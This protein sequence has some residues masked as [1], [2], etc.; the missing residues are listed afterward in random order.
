MK[1]KLL[2]LIVV[3]VIAFG[4]KAQAPS[5]ISFSPKNGSVGTLVTINGTGFNNTD[6]V[7]IGG[8]PAIIISK[9]SNK[10]LA[11]VMPN[12]ITGSV[13]LY[14]PGIV[15]IFSDSF[16]INPTKF[17]KVQQGNKLVGTDHITQVNGSIWS[18]NQQGYTVAISA[19]GNTA[20]V[21]GWEYNHYQG[22]VWT[23][24]KIGNRWVQQGDKLTANNGIGYTQ[25]GGSVALSGDG[26][27]AI[28]GGNGDNGYLGAA[29]IFERNGGVWIQQGN[30]LV[31][32]GSVGNPV[33]QGGSVAI[34]VDGNTAIIGGK[35]DSGYV[36]ASWV[37]SKINNIWTQQG[38]K[39]IGTGISDSARQGNA[40]AI[41]ADGNTVIV[42]GN[43]DSNANGASWIF[44]RNN[45]VWTQQGNKLFGTGSTGLSRQG[46][47]VA[48]SA[49]GN[50]AIV[51]GIS[52]SSGLGA[53]WVFV[54]NNNIWSQQGSKLVGMGSIGNKV[55]EGISVALN[56][57]GN[58]ALVGG[59]GDNNNLGAMWVFKRNNN[60]WTQQSN[61]LVGTGSV[62]NDIEQGWSLAI[63]A[64]GNTAILGG[65]TDSIAVGAAWIFTDFQ[66]P[67]STLSIDKIDT[68]TCSFSI[69]VPVRG[70]SLYNIST[71]K[72]SIH[73][74][75]AYLNLGGIKFDST[76]LKMNFNQIDVTHAANGY[77]TYNW[78][79]TIGHTVADSA[80]LFT[81]VMYPKPNVSGGTGIW[82]DSI[83]N[84]LEIVTAINVSAKNATF[85][86]GWIILSDTPQIIQNVNI[87]TCY[88][89]CLPMHYQWYYNGAPIQFDTLNYIY[90][91]GNGMYTC[92][93]TYRTG[94]TVSSNAINII[95]PVTLLSFKIQGL[96]EYNIVSWQ[97]AN[98][99][100]TS[101][102]N[103]QRTTDGKDFTT[104]WKVNAKG[105]SE[106]SYNDN[107]KSSRK[108]LYYRLEIVDKDGSKTYSEIRE[109]RMNNGQ[110]IISPNPANDYINISGV[111]FKSFRISDVSG[112]VIS[113]G[114]EKKVDI[115]NL[116]TGT[117]NITIE[118]MDG[119][120]EVRKFVKK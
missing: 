67:Y 51:G 20:I 29:W 25:F 107:E 118:C 9:D 98:E 103:I 10:V 39:L 76:Y 106:Y 15:T 33:Y 28:I 72:G 95:L 111:K 2:Y 77:L 104:I 48:L 112:R 102:F 65:R 4:V 6:S 42:G 1:L 68:T 116:N 57:D 101:H 30:K 79:D 37:F 89:G 93:V 108:V 60:I 13:K 105:A 110:L 115:N 82:F 81:M 21:G 44:K 64:D 69:D 71:L 50:T 55:F 24:T 100:N 80:P 52:D 88:A 66:Y 23:Y 14:L 83:P 5:L 113:A 56:A 16:T 38:N 59:S 70:N 58:I 62:G 45:N 91:T 53:S 31:G 99:I 27:I 54:R 84:K 8:I 22:A 92:T 3:I 36:G 114:K 63:S 43:Y 75:T 35:G 7:N 86:N 73:W 117:Y 109:L 46:S 97:T 94:H 41:S 96:K 74:D 87:L 17:P 119:S 49:D 18:I 19:D 12:A 32:S 34:S 47:S 90:P 78:S 85:N 26:N 40:V 120:I 11:M 61:K